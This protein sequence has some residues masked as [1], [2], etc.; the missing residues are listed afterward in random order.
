MRPTCCPRLAAASGSDTARCWTTCS[1]MGLEDSYE[2][3]TRGRLM[4]TFAEDCARH[5]DFTRADQDAYAIAS[6]TRAQAAIREGRFDWEVAAVAVPGRGGE[7]Q[8]LQDEQP[9]KAQLDK[10]PGLKPAFAK[11]GTVTAANFQ[12]HLRRRRGLGADAPLHRRGPRPHAA[13]HRVWPRHACPGA[14]VVHHRSGRRHAQAHRTPGLGRPGRGPVGDQ[15][16]LCGGH[17]GRHA[18]T[19]H[20]SREGQCARRCLC[21]GPPH[22]RLRR[23]HHRH[24]A[25]RLAPPR[26][27]RRGVASLCIGGGEATALALEL[28]A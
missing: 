15:R 21:A 8:V 26:A 11:D 6:T 28:P 27:L 1:S 2:P 12:F 9:L 3:A 24:A 4:G 19:L 7:R 18:R 20:P 10:I 25:G 13:G 17:D 14:G 5:F 22:R 16:G 23:P